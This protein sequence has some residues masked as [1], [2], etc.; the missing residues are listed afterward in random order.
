MLMSSAPLRDRARQHAR[1][2]TGLATIIAAGPDASA[3]LRAAV[4]SLGR[5][6]AR[7]AVAADVA[8]DVAPVADELGLRPAGAAPL[9]VCDLV[10][11]LAAAPSGGVER[12]VDADALDEVAELVA[13]AFDLNGSGVIGRDLYDAE[14]ADAWVL[15]DRQGH[16]VSALVA[17]ADPDLLGLWSLATPPAA[18]RRG[19]G[20][21]LL[22]AVLGNYALEGLPR[23]CVLATEAGEPL[24]RSLGFA[25]T[26]QLHV[27][28]KR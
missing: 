7:L 14:G 9:M 25:P 12:V 10:C 18:Q 1:R 8:A 6:P 11:D 21:H 19:H 15:R 24:Y 4:A 2:P 27:W 5:R 17:T 13:A 20:A 3:E 26:E 16:A 28:M 23:A 22:R